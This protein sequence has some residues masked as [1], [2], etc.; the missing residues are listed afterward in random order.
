VS[1]REI[2]RENAGAA[3]EIQNDAAMLV[4]VMMMT[5]VVLARRL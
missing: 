2:L 4:V 5:A 1:P 3:P